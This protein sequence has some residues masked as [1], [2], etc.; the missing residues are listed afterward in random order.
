MR[1]EDG[2]G[3]IEVVILLAILVGIALIFKEQ[4]TEF[5]EGILEDTLKHDFSFWSM[6]APF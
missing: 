5:V 3:T 2:F 4:I 1:K 6:Y